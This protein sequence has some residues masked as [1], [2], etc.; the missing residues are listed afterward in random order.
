MLPN[1]TIALCTHN[2]IDK[3]KKTLADL[4]LI[5]P[6]S[7]AWELLVIDNG[8][9]DGTSEYLNAHEWP[10]GWQVR[11]VREEKLG[12][13][14]ARNRSVEEAA[15]EFI[16]FIDDDET[17]DSLWLRSFEAVIEEHNPDAFG[18][19]ISVRIEGVKPPWLQDELLGFLGEL[20]ISEKPR[21]L[22]DTSTPLYTGNFGFR[23]RVCDMIGRFDA[24]LGRI[25]SRNEGGEDVEFYNRLALKGFNIRWAPEAVIYHRISAEKLNR[26]YFLD[27]HFR[28]G[29][30][31]GRQQRGPGS[32]LPPLHLFGQL[33]RAIAV[34][35]SCRRREGGDH[36]L[37]K[38]MNVSY[39][40]G[41][42]A[43]WVFGK[44]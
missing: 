31:E 19:K 24:R 29:R 9:T 34:A 37:R 22:T 6:P 25:G 41:F 39:F 36:S 33:K 15:G 28:E 16:I 1:L 42:I 4:R 44:R 11:I 12:I 38:E 43:G 18:G 40:L 27:L 7:A 17:P 13:A 23:K 32:R 2:H 26:R 8:S 5:E 3:L 30:M 20:N 14:N 10:A 21:Q 35:W